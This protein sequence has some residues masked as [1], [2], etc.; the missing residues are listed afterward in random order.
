MRPQSGAR[1]PLVGLRK[2]A[3]VM[4]YCT[5]GDLVGLDARAASRASIT[6]L[7]FSSRGFTYVGYSKRL[8]EKPCTA[9]GVL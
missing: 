1:L 5:D 7:V 3:N 8:V 9:P 4:R 6:A 2:F